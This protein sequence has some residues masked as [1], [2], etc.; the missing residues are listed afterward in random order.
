MKNVS[1]AAF[2][3]FSLNRSKATRTHAHTEVCIIAERMQ[4]CACFV[5]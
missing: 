2:Q 3:L 5:E 4:A 1:F